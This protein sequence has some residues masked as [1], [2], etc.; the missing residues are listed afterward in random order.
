[1]I[2][3]DVNSLLE[4]VSKKMKQTFGESLSDVILFG[5]YA[6]G[7][8]DE[9][10]D[11]DIAIVVDISREDLKAFHKDFVK[12]MTDLAMKYD[13]VVSLIDIPLSDFNKYKEV[14]PFYKNISDEGVRISA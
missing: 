14:L 11:V 8:F 6:R 2:K 5:S 9:E 3:T 10:S 7:D 4:Y 1:M 12:E 13:L